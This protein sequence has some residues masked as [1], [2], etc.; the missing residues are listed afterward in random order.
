M[1]LLV[2]LCELLIN[3]TRMHN[4]RNAIYLIFQYTMVALWSALHPE[5]TRNGSFCCVAS[6]SS[7]FWQFLWCTILQFS[8]LAVSVV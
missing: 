7:L 1:H 6:C 3:Y 2:L 5:E 4:F 8:V